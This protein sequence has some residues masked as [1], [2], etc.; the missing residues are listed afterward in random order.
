MGWRG[1]A[2]TGDAYDKVVSPARRPR[3]AARLVHTVVSFDF[4]VR[5]VPRAGTR[6]SSRPTSSRARSS[7][8][9]AMVLLLAI[10]L[11]VVY[12]LEDFITMRHLQNMAKILATG[13]IVGYGYV[14]R[15]V[16]GW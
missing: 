13:L 7:P 8:G 16:D 9:F 1:S 12:G 3:D 14:M 5:I 10:P 6:R 11:R 15:M 2:P 4:A